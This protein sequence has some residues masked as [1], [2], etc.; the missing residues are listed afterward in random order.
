MI[1]TLA[2][3]YLYIPFDG[4]EY[5]LQIFIWSGEKSTPPATPQYSITKQNVE[6]STDDDKVNIARLVND[7]IDFTPNLPNTVWVKT[8]VI[9]DVEPELITTTLAVQGN[10]FGLDGENAQPPSNGILLSGNEFKVN[11][12]GFFNIPVLVPEDTEKTLNINSFP[13][14]EIEMSITYDASFNS[15]ELLKNYLLDISGILTDEYIE[16][17]Y[18][19][20]IVELLIT[21]ECR[22]TPI[23]I[24]FQNK[25]GALQFI[26]F[27]KAKT[28]SMTVTNEMFESDRGQP[29]N[30]NHQFV[31]YN[32]QANSKFKINSGFVD[33]S[34][35]ETFKQ[36]FLSEKVWQFKNENYIPL[37]LGS[38]SLEYKTRQKDRLINY[39]VEFEYAFN[40]INNV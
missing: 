25:E 4:P 14:G 18:N 9:Y 7:Y 8:Q 39:E 15:N 30:G 28:E 16:I 24:A 33:E 40:E 23:D 2:P 36:L 6:S 5:T 1:K 13:L 38:K 11:K 34:M 20:N 3:Y 19:E 27:F 21:D 32:V 22:Y 10:T 31:T 35:N 26:T 37:K 17:G 29:I 12:N